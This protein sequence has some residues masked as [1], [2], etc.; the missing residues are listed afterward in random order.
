MCFVCRASST[1]RD[2]AFSNFAANA[3]WRDTIWEHDEYMEFLKIHG[4]PIPVLLACVIGFTLSCVMI[5]V[6]HTVDLGLASHIIGNILWIQANVRNVFGG[7]NQETRVSRLEN[8]ISKWYSRNKKA[9]KMQHKLIIERLRTK[10]SWPKLKAKAAATRHLARYA[11]ELMQLHFDDTNDENKEYDTM[12]LTVIRLLVRFYDILESSSMFLS[13]DVKK[14]LP[15]LA[16]QLGTC[17]QRLAADAFARGLR[18]WKI[19]PK[20][21]LFMH[22]CE[23][24]AIVFGN[25]RFYWTYA[26]EDLVRHMIEIASSVHPSTL[27]VISFP[28][29]CLY[30]TNEL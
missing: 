19:T 26:D 21:H 5:D 14:E 27:A 15:T 28:T 8:D 1:N 30:F 24:Q 13:N 16:L 22:L 25:P 10:K 9:C 20:L 18:L 2:L 7:S 11:L 23:I 3:G 4:L 29:G 6:L 17:Y 12:C